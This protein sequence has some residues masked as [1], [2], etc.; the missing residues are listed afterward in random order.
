MAE[1]GVMDDIMKAEVGDDTSI[2]DDS[3]QQF[4]LLLRVT[5]S[6]GKPLPVDGF[7]G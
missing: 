3:S 6:N 5:Q 4:A 1:G 2:G 7:T